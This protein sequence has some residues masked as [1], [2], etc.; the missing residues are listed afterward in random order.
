[1]FC[2]F[3]KFARRAVCYRTYPKIAVQ[4]VEVREWL[5]RLCEQVIIKL[6]RPRHWVL[7]DDSGKQGC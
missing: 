4:Y 6:D 2:L 7:I 5:V 1:M 3:M